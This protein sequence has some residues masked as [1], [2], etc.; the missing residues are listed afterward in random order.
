MQV[1]LGEG[2]D[3]FVPRDC[4][5]KLLARECARPTSAAGGKLVVF[6]LGGFDGVDELVVE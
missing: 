3:V 6:E 1:A 2:D 5:L 4:G